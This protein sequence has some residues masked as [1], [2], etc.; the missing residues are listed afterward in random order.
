MPYK[1]IGIH[2]H[3]RSGKDTVA[4]YLAK[5]TGNLAISDFTDRPYFI[6][7]FAESLK[8]CAHGIFGVSLYEEVDK[9]KIIPEWGISQRIILQTLGVSLRE[10][11]GE[12]IFI[13]SLIHKINTRLR[14]SF[15]S[16]PGASRSQIYIIIPDVRFQ[17]ELDWIYSQ[18]GTILHIK[19]PGAD[20]NV[21]I[22]QHI[23]EANLTLKGEHTY[24]ILND[25]SLEDLE[26]EVTCVFKQFIASK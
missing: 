5:H 25:G 7:P 11:F 21:G 19:R 22:P 6:I 15:C 14:L 17:N 4:K 10:T 9:E 1:I 16:A 18:G 13:N 8:N 23:S 20:G 3:A 2:G 26:K 12:N 24:V